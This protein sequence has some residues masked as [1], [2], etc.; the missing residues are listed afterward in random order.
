MTKRQAAVVLARLAIIAAILGGWQLAVSARVVDTFT[1]SSPGAVFSLIG[2]WFSSGYVWPHLIST[3]VVFLTGYLIGIAGGAALGLICGIS[4]LARDYFSPFMIFFNSI[5]RLV[6]I[7]FLI[8]WL[9]FGYAP[10]IIVVILV[11]LFVVALPVQAGVREIDN[12]VIRNARVL[13]AGSLDLVRQIYIPAV[14]S[15]LTSSARASIGLAFQAAVVAEFFGGE[16]G[17][18]YLITQGGN[19]YDSAQIYAAIILTVALAVILDGGVALASRRLLRWM[20]NSVPARRPWRASTRT[21]PAGEDLSQQ[22][23]PQR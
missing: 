22:A 1:V 18:G 8:V 23:V 11:I 2:R 12:D 17:L 21:E 15:W 19:T 9:G 10:K 20:P 5:P 3:L 6:L 16:R 7:P 14:G 4:K 13:G